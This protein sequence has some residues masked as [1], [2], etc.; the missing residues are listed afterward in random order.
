LGVREVEHLLEPSLEPAGRHWPLAVAG[1]PH[2]EAAM[3]F[4]G[5]NDLGQRAAE[6][7]VT[8]RRT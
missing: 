8:K 4:A 5:G 2:F 7:Q 1:A 6:D 3:K